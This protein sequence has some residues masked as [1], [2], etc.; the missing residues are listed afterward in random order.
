M[1]DEEKEEPIISPDT[2]NATHFHAIE[3]P[4]SE[5]QKFTRFHGY[6]TGLYNGEWANET[7]LRRVDNLAL[8]DAVS[9]QLELTTYQKRTGRMLFDSLNLKHLGYRAVLVAFA[10]CAHVC[11]DDGRVYH[12]NRAA[13][14]NDELFVSFADTL[15]ESP[16]T[17][18]ACYNRISSE[19]A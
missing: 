12:P 16:K 3:A 6:N 13:E 8:F 11:R 7:A 5:R 18:K 14:N 4:P 1:Y 19:V 10:V 17:I 15:T 2:E 9:S